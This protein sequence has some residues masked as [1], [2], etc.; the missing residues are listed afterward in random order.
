MEVAN[1]DL[2]FLDEIQV[3]GNGQIQT[4]NCGESCLWAKRENNKMFLF[5]WISQRRKL[6]KLFPLF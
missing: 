6:L 2:D 4:Q 5:L 3:E 1:D